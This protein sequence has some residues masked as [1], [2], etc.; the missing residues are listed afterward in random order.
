MI[1]KLLIIYHYLINYN[2]KIIKIIIK[3]ITYYYNNLIL[4]KNFMYYNMKYN[5]NKIKQQ[6]M[7]NKII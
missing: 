5:I 4:M 7:Y 2:N 1:L 6:I 3:F